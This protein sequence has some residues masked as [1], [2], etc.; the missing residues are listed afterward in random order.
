MLRSFKMTIFE[1]VKYAIEKANFSDDN[2]GINELISYAYYL[3]KHDAA[4]DCCKQA[5]EIFSEQLKKAKKCRYHK[6]ALEIQGNI[7]GI[8]HGDYSTYF[9]DAFKYDRVADTLIKF[10]RAAN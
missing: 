10:E 4:V 3:G 5:K 1:K 6:K 8:Y 9:I 2:N 7:K